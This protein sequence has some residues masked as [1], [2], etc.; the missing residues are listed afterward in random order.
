MTKETKIGLLVGLAFILLVGILLSDHFRGTMEPATAPLDHA[1]ATVRQAVNSPGSNVDPQPVVMAPAE[2]NPHS[3]IQTPRDITPLKPPVEFIPVANGNGL[4]VQTG[5]PGTL[6]PNDPLVRAAQAQGEQIVPA[7]PAS[8]SVSQ[9]IQIAAQRTYTAQ[10][11]DSVSRMAA[12][13]LGANTARN[14]QAIIAANPSLQTDPNKVVTG[15]SYVIP[16]SGPAAASGGSSTALSATAGSQFIYVVKEG[17][18][19]WGIA[20]GQLGKPGAVQA[21]KELNRDQLHGTNTLVPG[22]RL[23]LPSAPVAIAE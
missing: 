22:M 16:G 10:S 7:D 12:R 13:L 6:P 4:P 1:G 14:R 18:T 9:P 19:L 17:D 23:R 2:V 15:Q 11:G 3:A 5:T 21:I 20:T 8:G